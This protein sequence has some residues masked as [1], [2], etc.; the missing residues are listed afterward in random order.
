MTEEESV[1]EEKEYIMEKEREDEDKEERV[2]DEEEE[3]WFKPARE[4]KRKAEATE[5]DE[6]SEYERKP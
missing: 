1:D 3:G 5:K 6:D 4:L 2:K